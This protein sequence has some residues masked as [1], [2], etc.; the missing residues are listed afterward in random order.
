MWIILYLSTRTWHSCGISYS[1]SKDS[2]TLEFTEFMTEFLLHRY[3]CEQNQ[4][5]VSYVP[6]IRHAL[7][8]AILN[9]SKDLERKFLQC[10]SW[11]TQG[12][13]SVSMGKWF[14]TLQDDT[15]VSSSRV[16]C[17]RQTIW[18]LKM[19]M[20]HSSGQENKRKCFRCGM[21]H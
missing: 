15:V 2:I 17:P 11:G 7:D 5:N 20:V 10:C 13:D 16:K 19:V 4:W 12:H 3:P 21:Y 8:T 14:P 1:Q 6:S 9:R 18:P